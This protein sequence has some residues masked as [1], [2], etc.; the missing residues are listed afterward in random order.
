MTNDISSSTFN[1]DFINPFINSAINVMKT[2][3]SIDPKP[4]KP[5]LKNSHSTWGMVTGVIGMTG[6]KLIGNMV[7]S[8]DQPCILEIVS[9]MLMDQFD[10][11]TPDVVD[12]VGEL[13]NM[14]TGGAK[15]QLVELGYKFE[16]S[17]PMMITGMNVEISQLTKVPIIVVP[18]DTLS[19]RFVIEA[20]FTP[21]S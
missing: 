4:G 12:A 13:T 15:M 11:V 7:L 18:F 14:I 17:T 20:S 6:E 8:F 5:Y 3:A 21:P 2:M 10:K 16:M 19:G 1:A 9:A